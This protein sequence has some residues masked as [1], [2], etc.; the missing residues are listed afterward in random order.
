MKWPRNSERQQYT[1]SCSSVRL[2][3]FITRIH[4]H[5]Y[6][7][8]TNIQH[9]R[10]RTC[11]WSCTDPWSSK[12]GTSDTGGVQHQTE[13]LGQVLLVHTTTYMHN[14]SPKV[15]QLCTTCTIAR[16]RIT[17]TTSSMYQSIMGRCHQLR[18]TC[19]LFF[20]VITTVTIIILAHNNN[21]LSQ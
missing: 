13:Q 21:T 2:A 20:A 15:Q 10:T 8:R 3:S 17:Y 18:A 1:S 6:T 16:V 11:I 19:F 14:Q 12:E 4:V 9:T 5:T 7:H